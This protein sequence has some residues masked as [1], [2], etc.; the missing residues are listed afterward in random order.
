MTDDDDIPNKKYVDDVYAGIW[1]KDS[2]ASRDY[3]TPAKVVAW[4]DVTGGTAGDMPENDA[5]G[6][7]TGD[8]IT[9]SATGAG[10]YEICYSASFSGDNSSLVELDVQADGVDVE[11]SHIDRKLGLSGDVGTV[12]CNTIAT[13]ANDDVITLFVTTDETNITFRS[14]SLT[15]KKLK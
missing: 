15:V 2:T 6:D 10:V 12:A 3:S 4:T 11:G 1:V 5:D 8:D 7:N 13:L 14:V 9:I